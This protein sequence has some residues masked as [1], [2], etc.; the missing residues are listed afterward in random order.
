MLKEFGISWNENG[1]PNTSNR[2]TI[3]RT[4]FFLTAEMFQSELTTGT[5]K[6]IVSAKTA[7]QRIVEV[8]HA[9]LL[10]KKNPQKIQTI[11][12]GAA[13]T[14]GNIAYSLVTGGALDVLAGMNFIGVVGSR[15]SATCI[16]F[17]TAG[18]YGWWREIVCQ[19]L[20]TTPES[21]KIKKF[22]THIFAFNTSQLPIYGAALAI[23]SLISDGHVDFDKVAHGVTYL[24]CISPLIGP[25]LGWF[26]DS[27][28]KIFGIK[29]AEEG[30]YK[31]SEDETEKSAVVLK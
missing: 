15:A 18:A 25:S 13:D 21:G 23:G 26:M 20:K 17:V 29:P 12:I 31:K 8:E 4:N 28:R 6:H 22:A 16:N 10:E 30:A 1:M 24:F 9:K 11:K 14:L 3:T 5:T 19:T 2:N 7:K 27:I